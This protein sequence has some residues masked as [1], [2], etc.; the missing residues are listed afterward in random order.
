MKENVLSVYKKARLLFQDWLYEEED[1]IGF[2]FGTVKAPGL[3]DLDLGVIIKEGGRISNQELM[4]ALESF[5]SKISRVMNGGTLM[6]FKENNFKQIN[7]IDDINVTFFNNDNFELSL[8]SNNERD[9]IGIIQIIEWLPERIAK[10]EKEIVNPLKNTK[11]LIGFY[12]SLCYTLEKIIYYTGSSEELTEFI[13]KTKN[14]RKNWINNAPKM[15]NAALKSIEKTYLKVCYNAI[16]R[17]SEFVR[18][19]NLIFDK[20]NWSDIFINY[21]L[22][23]N[24]NL[25]YKKAFQYSDFVSHEDNK[26]KILVPIEFL[27]SYILYSHSNSVLG[28]KIR[29]RFITKGFNVD[30]ITD[31]INPNIKHVLDIRENVFS[32]MFDFIYSNEINRG[33]YKFGWYLND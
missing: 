17:F 6:I 29:K 2:E 13:N 9:F 3:S 10:I 27:S 14:L 21:N 19:S 8:P 33:L 7:Y 5:P 22:H 23:S 24:V 1:L 15:N 16:I 30:L 31:A 28:N 4:N 32:E 25:Q 20:Y 11:R 26:L 12:Y 18:S